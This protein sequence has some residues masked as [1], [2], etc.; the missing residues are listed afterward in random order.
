M[1]DNFNYDDFEEFLQDQVKNHRMYPADAVWREIDKKLHGEK[2]WPALTIAAAML[3]SATVLICVYFSPKP[4]LF[5]IPTANVNTSTKQASQKDNILSHLTPSDPFAK[6]NQS[7]EVLTQ[8]AAQLPVATTVISSNQTIANN[9]ANN[10]TSFT[11]VREA[12]VS[13]KHPS[14]ARVT[15]LSNSSIGKQGLSGV[16]STK[17]ALVENTNDANSGLNNSETSKEIKLA[18]AL[19]AKD[20][21]KDISLDKTPVSTPASVTSHPVFAKQSLKHKFSYQLYI[22]PS[23]SYRKLLEDNSITKENTAGPVGVNYVTDVNK[24]VRHKPGTGIEAG[25]AIMYNLSDKVRVKSGFQFNMRQYSIQAYRSSTELASIALVGSNRI[26]T[27]NTLAIYRNNN[28]YYSAQLVNRY[29]QLSVPVGIEWEVIGNKKIQLNVAGTIQPTYLLNRNAYLLSTNFKN[30]TENP[31]MVRQWNI[32]SNI[33][34]FMSFKAGD[35]KWQIGPQ[36]RYQPYSTFIPEYTI[37]EHLMDYGI[38]LGLSKTI[39]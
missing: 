13:T 36:L 6:G 17:D 24:V 37:K 25:V 28:G 5:S 2:R 16:S 19:P 27:I 34:A 7:A 3:V 18:E 21:K 29:Y 4:D 1:E 23:V 14:N 12:V 38:K 35:F 33:E 11:S 10:T 9:V 32:N 30:Y 39:N 31:G 20:S 15:S 26:D 8:K 22:A